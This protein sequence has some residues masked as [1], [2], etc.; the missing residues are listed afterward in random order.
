MGD[1]KSREKTM[2]GGGSSR[3]LAA[4]SLSNSHPF[5]QRIDCRSG[6]TLWS[7]RFRVS[8][9]DRTRVYRCGR[10]PNNPARG[11]PCA[12]LCATLCFRCLFL[13][14]PHSTDT[15]SDQT[16]VTKRQG[17]GGKSARLDLVDDQTR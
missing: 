1:E 7:K 13:Q 9:P 16:R 6:Q 4:L 17:Y 3:V 11:T 12:G 8:G 15:E 10:T 5:R 14:I 2:K